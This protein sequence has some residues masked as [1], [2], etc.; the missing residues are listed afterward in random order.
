MIR[1]LASVVMLG[2][3]VAFAAG[4]DITSRDVNTV[5]GPGTGLPMSPLTS[6]RDVLESGDR[7]LSE[8]LRA[9]GFVFVDRVTGESI[10]ELS[11]CRYEI[12]Q[13]LSGGELRRSPLE[14]GCLIAPEITVSVSR[15]SNGYFR[16]IY[17]VT[18]H[19]S[20]EQHVYG[21]GIGIP[22]PDVIVASTEAHGWRLALVSTPLAPSRAM[23]RP[24]G[25]ALSLPPGE[26]VGSLS[27]TSQYWPGITDA[28][29]VGGARDRVLDLAEEP[30]ARLEAALSTV[31]Q[32]AKVADATI[33][34][35]IPPPTLSGGTAGIVDRLASDVAVASSRGWLSE[36]T[37]DT[38]HEVIEDA[39]GVRASPQKLGRLA[40]KISSLRVGNASYRRALAVTLRAMATEQRSGSTVPVH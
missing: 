35:V 19:R 10:K 17:T 24:L 5:A 30:S 33:G 25:G 7:E 9:Q 26:T 31:Y 34:P 29:F 28:V 1:Y 3:S 15:L 14:V 36:P 32:K 22:A 2:T 39:R 21:F 20:A 8:S 40:G 4:P 23:W 27:I 13:R 37:T 6:P 11:P 16:Y 38:V 18:N 12:V